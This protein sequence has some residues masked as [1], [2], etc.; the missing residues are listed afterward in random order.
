VNDEVKE[1]GKR[2][3]WPN[4]KSYYYPGIRLEGLKKT[5]E[6]LGKGSRFLGRDLNPG[7]PKYEAGVLTT[8][9]RRTMRHHHG[10]MCVY[11]PACSNTGLLTGLTG[12]WFAIQLITITNLR[13]SENNLL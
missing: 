1:F 11:S 13:R 9:P 10:D 8:R 12:L 6:T 3:Q 2:Q 7:S 5:T 4:F